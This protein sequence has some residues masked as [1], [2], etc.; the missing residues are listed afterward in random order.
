MFLT[1]CASYQY[2]VT[3]PDGGALAVMKD[4]DLIV[5]ADPVR[6]RLRQVESRCVLIIDNPTADAVTIDGMASAIVDPTGQSRPIATQLIA[7]GSYVKLILP[8]LL[9]VDPRGPRLQL[10]LGFIVNATTERQ[11]DYLET[12]AAQ[13]YWE[14]PGEGTVR[15]LL[16]IKTK[17]Q[18]FK[19]ELTLRKIKT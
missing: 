11:A 5:P 15:I 14:W 19:H 7:P 17:D 4:Q 6:L 3:T 9:D 13:D 16:S 12:G 10:G 18:T 8:P 1:G 2:D